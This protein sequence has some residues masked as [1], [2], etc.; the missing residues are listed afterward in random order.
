MVKAHKYIDNI[1]VKR[2]SKDWFK[3]S[4]YPEKLIHMAEAL[5]RNAE[6][7]TMFNA[8]AHYT[9]LPY[10]FVDFATT[11]KKPHHKA[12]IDVLDG[13]SPKALDLSLILGNNIITS[14]HR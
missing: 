10:S 14:A 12:H 3:L 13:I 4:T 6:D 1:Q 8:V 7:P 9:C 5:D 2:G 11:G